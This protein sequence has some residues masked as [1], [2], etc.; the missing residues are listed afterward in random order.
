MWFTNCNQQGAIW[1]LHV[2]SCNLHVASCNLHVASCNLHVA[3]CNLHVAMLHSNYNIKKPVKNII[4]SFNCIKN[5][6][7]IKNKFDLWLK[8]N[9]HNIYFAKKNNI[10][11]THKPIRGMDTVRNLFLIVGPGKPYWRGWLSTIDL[12]IK[13]GCLG[14]KYIFSMK[15]SWSE[16]VSSRRSTVL[17]LPLQ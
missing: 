7:L 5:K 12:L 14:K 17:I 3:S 2:A 16:L 15:S 6:F 10:Y 13:I 4:V 8:R 9:N 1:N 11:K